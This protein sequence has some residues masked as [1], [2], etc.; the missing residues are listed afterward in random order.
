MQLIK[1][2]PQLAVG[3]VAG[4]LLGTTAV[5]MAQTTTTSAEFC[6]KDSGKLRL[7]VDGTCDEN[8]QLLTIV[9][10]QG[11]AG[12][13]GVDGVDG[14]DGIDGQDG[15]DGQ[16]GVSGYEIVT[17]V[18]LWGGGGGTRELT[19]YCPPGKKVF[20]FGYNG[21]FFTVPDFGTS[22]DNAFI[23]AH[24]L[25]TEPVDGGNGWNFFWVGDF[26]S[27]NLPYEHYIF[28]AYA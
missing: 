22:S 1:R 3:L 25:T 16:N 21:G 15:V 19:M 10:A 2:A 9:G 28:C 14:Q 26:T 8:E 24:L 5:A 11:P 17:E 20:G 12:Q 27:S 4:L 23:N 6:V 7:A 18:P 13:D